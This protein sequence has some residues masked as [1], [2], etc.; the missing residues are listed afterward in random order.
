MAT[1]RAFFPKIMELIPVFEKGQGRSP[2]SSSYTA[3]VI[4]ACRIL[5]LTKFAIKKLKTDVFSVSTMFPL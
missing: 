4:R 1:I 3:V 2:S 5:K